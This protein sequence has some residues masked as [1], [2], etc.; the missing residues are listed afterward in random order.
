MNC[1]IEFK[2][3]L[4][5]FEDVVNAALEDPA[6]LA[7][8]SGNSLKHFETYHTPQ[9]HAKHIIRSVYREEK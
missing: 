6:R 2:E 7:K 4:S 5:D 9:A 8:I 1:W 3:D